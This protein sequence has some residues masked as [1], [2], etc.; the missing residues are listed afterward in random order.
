MQTHLVRTL[1]TT[2]ADFQKG[3]IR[4]LQSISIKKGSPLPD[5]LLKN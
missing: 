5:Y 1:Q 3:A 2:A 4:G